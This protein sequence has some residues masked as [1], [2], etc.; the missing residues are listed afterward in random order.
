MNKQVGESFFGATDPYGSQCHALPEP[1][2]GNHVAVAQ[3]SSLE[4][5]RMLYYQFASY[6][7]Y[8]KIHARSRAYPN[9]SSG[10]EPLFM[11]L[12]HSQRVLRMQAAINDRLEAR[13]QMLEHGTTILHW[14]F[15]DFKDEQAECIPLSMWF[16]L[17]R[18]FFVLRI[19]LSRCI[20]IAFLGWTMV[21]S[22]FSHV[23]EES[24]ADP[25]GAVSQ[26]WTRWRP[27]WTG[28]C[29]R[30]WNR[31]FCLPSEIHLLNGKRGF[32]KNM[33]DA[34]CMEYLPTFGQFLG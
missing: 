17:I 33:I 14:P 29:G 3:I 18:S 32:E 8:I 11:P 20:F 34:P 23:E 7:E 10:A 31:S 22:G 12:E 16:A 5:P 6:T 15:H 24:L 27:F 28:C 9:R 19:F 13:I 30:A 1:R 2:G 26:P 4:P 25:E 21:Q